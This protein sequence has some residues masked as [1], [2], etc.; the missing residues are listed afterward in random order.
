M[1]SLS[2]DAKNITVPTRSFSTSVRLSARL[3]RRLALN[4][5]STA[6]PALTTNPGA[7]VCTDIVI[8]QLSRH[9]A[10][11]GD[12]RAFRRDVMNIILAAVERGARR[13]VDDLASALLLH[14][15]KR[16]FGAQP[17]ATHVDRHRLVELIDFHLP[18]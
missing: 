4:A 9:R 5:G 17:R 13:N 15:R 16:R 1:K 18:E 8:A 7:R 10:S 2:G 6:G 3:A 11:H 12:Q 14:V